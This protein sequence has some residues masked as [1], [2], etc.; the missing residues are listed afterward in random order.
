V[1]G[2]NLS[3]KERE[4]RVGRVDDVG[5]VSAERAVLDAALLSGRATA[6]GRADAEK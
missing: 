3:Q 6:A 4:A 1:L 2:E 5:D